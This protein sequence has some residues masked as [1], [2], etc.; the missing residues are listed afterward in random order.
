VR[1]IEGLYRV[2]NPGLAP[3]FRRARELLG[4][5]DRW[6]IAHV[7]REQN[8]RAD[9]LAAAAARKGR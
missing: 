2:K 5:F 1:Q 8:T 9:E 7:P 3:L 4:G 6:D